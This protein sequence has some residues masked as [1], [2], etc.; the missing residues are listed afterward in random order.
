M[1][2]LLYKETTIQDDYFKPCDVQDNY[3]Q[4]IENEEQ[5]QISSSSK[6]RKKWV[7]SESEFDPKSRFELLP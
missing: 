4:P 2:I 3:F 5:H 6:Q 7:G 1:T